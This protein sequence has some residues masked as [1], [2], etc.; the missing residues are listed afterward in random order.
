MMC[1]V[2]GLKEFGLRQPGLDMGSLTEREAEV[3][4]RLADCRAGIEPLIGHAKQDGQLKQS[5]MKT[6][7]CCLKSFY[8]A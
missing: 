6:L 1:A 4:A 5:W 8:R 3:H 7:K 2:K